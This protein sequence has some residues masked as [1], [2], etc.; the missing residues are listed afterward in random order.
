M[1]KTCSHTRTINMT[2]CVPNRETGRS[3]APA[4]PARGRPCTNSF[5][6]LDKFFFF[7]RPVPVTPGTFAQTGFY[8][9]AG[10]AGGK[11]GL[12][13]VKIASRERRGFYC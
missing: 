1:K 2:T 6:P 12:K 3:A 7:I 9:Q 11:K 10:Q 5:K 8:R 13:D 4:A